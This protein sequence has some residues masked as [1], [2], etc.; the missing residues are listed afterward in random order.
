MVTFMKIKS[1]LL[2]ALVVC[3][4]LVTLFKVIEINQSYESMVKVRIYL[5]ETEN[6]NADSESFK[7]IEEELVK[8][9]YDHTTKVYS[10]EIPKEVISQVYNKSFDKYSNPRNI[11]LSSFILSVEMNKRNNYIAVTSEWSDNLLIDKANGNYIF[12][13]TDSFINPE[14]VNSTVIFLTPIF[15]KIE[16]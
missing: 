15:N 14:E 7:R 13:K 10:I 3:V 11:H 2:T 5:N 9:K 8:M 6:R 12:F 4:A 16:S 1:T